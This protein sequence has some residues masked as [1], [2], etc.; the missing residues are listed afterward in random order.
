MKGCGWGPGFCVDRG[1]G[2]SRGPQPREPF[3]CSQEALLAQIPD[4]RP[5][6]PKEDG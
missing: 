1:G 3:L 5:A 6:D 2:L 4:W